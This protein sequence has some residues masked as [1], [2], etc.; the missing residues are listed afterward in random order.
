MIRRAPRGF[1]LV[2]LLVVIAIIGILVGLLLPAVQAAREAARRTSCVNNLKQIGLA[3][4]NYHDVHQSFPSGWIALD[5]ATRL[6]LAEGEPGWG[7]A[8]MVLPFLE[9]QNVSEGM[10]Q[11]PLPITDPVHAAARV[12]PLAVFRCKSDTG[13]P[14]F[15]L[16][17]EGDPTQNLAT[18]AT[19]NYVGVFGTVE[20]EDCEGLPPGVI[21]R[22]NGSFQ[23][24]EGVRLAELLDGTSSTLLV[25]ERSARLGYSTWTG[26]VSEGEEAMARILGIADHAPNHPGA[27][28]DDFTSEHPAGTNFLLGDGSVRLIVETIDLGVYQGLATRAGGEVVTG[29]D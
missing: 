27:H 2:E 16:A 25:G 5:P 24:I 8:S 19:A 9:Q 26:A 10:I 3:L 18:L 17:A 23:H 20:L 14:T 13:R 6:P 4:H 15:D 21:C 29:R 22:G 11:F 1:T 12:Q 7:W 28:L